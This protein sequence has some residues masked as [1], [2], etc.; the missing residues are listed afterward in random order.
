MQNEHMDNKKNEKI[1]NFNIQKCCTMNEENDS[2]GNIEKVTVAVGERKRTKS[3]R[4]SSNA[5]RRSI[6]YVPGQK[7][8]WSC[9]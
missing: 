7:R 3:N 2:H 9:F 6:K 1:V 8:S 4:P 5:W